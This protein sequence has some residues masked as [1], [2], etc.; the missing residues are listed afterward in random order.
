MPLLVVL[1]VAIIAIL[2][3][4]FQQAY[5]VAPPA[6]LERIASTKLNP[7]ENGYV[8]EL[9]KVNGREV[10]VLID[11]VASAVSFSYE[12]AE[13]IGLKPSMLKFNVPVFTP[14]GPTQAAAVKL[15]WIEVNG[16]GAADVDGL[17]M[18]KGTTRGSVLG[19]WFLSHLKYSKLEDGTLLLEN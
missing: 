8:M 13:R 3:G 17:V 14:Q 18:P 5:T 6:M 7:K 4:Q 12:D 1:P 9:A 10:K 15:D 2:V 19:Q 16:V 11:P